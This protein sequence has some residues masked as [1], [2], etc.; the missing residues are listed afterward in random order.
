MVKRE[1]E[2]KKLWKKYKELDR[3]SALKVELEIKEWFGTG[4]QSLFDDMLNN[5][6]IAFVHW[7]Y[8]YEKKDGSINPNFLR[9]FR[10]VLREVCCE[11][12]YGKHGVS[13]SKISKMVY[14][15]IHIIKLQKLLAEITVSSFII[16]RF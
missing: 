3:N 5:V 14:R 1:H 2:L 8:I 4:N 11:Q 9:G 7:R 15:Q 13:T 10:V 16:R 6:S 12:Y